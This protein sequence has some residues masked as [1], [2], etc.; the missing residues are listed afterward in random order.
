M[1]STD[2]VEERRRRLVKSAIEKF[3]LDLEGLTVFTEAAT[4][5]Y[6]YNPIISALAGSNH[7]FAVT[8]DSK[9]GKK[10]DVKEQTLKEAKKL[11]VED[12]VT[13]LFEK[14]MDC[15]SKSDIV[16]NSGFVRPITNEMVSCMKSTAVI[17]LMFT[18]K[19]FRTEDID[20]KA[21][22]KKGVI[23]LG[24]NEHHPLLN[25]FGYVGFYMCKL[26]FE[27]NL[28]VFKNKLLLI[29]SGDLGNYPTDFF[30]KNN[31][32][33][34]RITFDGDVPEHQKAFVRSRDEII[35][36]LGSYDAIIIAELHHDI[37]ILSNN[38]FIPVGILKEKNPLVQIIHIAGSISRDDV[39]KKNLALYPKDIKP[40]GYQSVSCDC[41]GPNCT[42]ELNTAGLKVGEVAARARLNGLTTEEAIQVAL[43][44]S[45]AQE[46]GK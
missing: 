24:V 46:L 15:L 8:D 30:L 3:R 45:P 41:L 27:M 40:F 11:G 17:P 6:L 37:D 20:I 10:E 25:M 7:V 42:I 31:I 2:V 35:E 43:R 44:S 22:Q 16:T 5:N 14:D 12:K 34:D 19:N 26:L 18:A 33:I 29:G 28:S 32:S 36:K 21:C 38:G 9:Y 39:L 23:V 4:G 13:V 1:N